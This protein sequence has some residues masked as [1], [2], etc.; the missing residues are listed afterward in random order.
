MKTTDAVKLFASLAQETRL[1]VLRLLVEAGPDGL[2]AGTLSDRLQMA[3]NT[4][5]FHLRQLKSA[6]LIQSHKQGRSV[7]YAAN[8][9][10]ITSL[11]DFLVKDCC[12][13]SGTTCIN[14]QRSQP[15]PQALADQDKPHLKFNWS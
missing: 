3:H 2:P 10:R 8:F 9:N 7:I 4:M 5:S 11:V 12:A 14:P 15:M 6:G 1:S 13:S